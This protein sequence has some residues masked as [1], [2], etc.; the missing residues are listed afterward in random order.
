MSAISD[1][2]DEVCRMDGTTGP[3]RRDEE[4]AHERVVYKGRGE[5]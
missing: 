4:G 2:S 1:V 3:P 5:I